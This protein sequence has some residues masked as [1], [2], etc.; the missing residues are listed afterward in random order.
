MGAFGS[1]R[2]TLGCDGVQGL[3]NAG[4]HYTGTGF[5]I[6]GVPSDGSQAQQNRIGSRD[7][8]YQ[9]STRTTRGSFGRY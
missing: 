4:A 6:L 7:M 9:N 2:G 5:W 3:G 1:P 8:V